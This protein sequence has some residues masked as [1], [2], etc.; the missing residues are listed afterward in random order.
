MTLQRSQNQRSF[1]LSVTTRDPKRIHFA[2]ASLGGVR[3]ASFKRSHQ[4]PLPCALL[5]KGSHLLSSRQAH[6]LEAV[7]VMREYLSKRWR[8]GMGEGRGKEGGRERGG[9]EGG[10]R[11]IGRGRGGGGRKGGERARE[12]RSKSAQTVTF[13]AYLTSPSSPFPPCINRKTAHARHDQRSERDHV[14]HCAH[15]ARRSHQSIDHGPQGYLLEV[16][17]GTSRTHGGGA[18]APDAALG[19]QYRYLDVS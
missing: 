18:R 17:P 15:C 12:R 10:G 16:D 5:T 9:G 19:N 3:F 4:L 1:L 13:C 7:F 11:E 2:I 6:L 14:C 8:R